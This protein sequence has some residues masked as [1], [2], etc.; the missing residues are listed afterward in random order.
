MKC[1]SFAVFAAWALLSFSASAQFNDQWASFTEDSSMLSAGTIT[2][3]N[4]EADLAWGDLDNDGA[5]DLV[6][7]RKQPFT[8]TGKRTNLLLMN[9]NGVL[10]DRTST[11]ASDAD[12][13]GDQGFQTATNDR[14][15]VLTDVD[16]DGFLDVVTATTL[17]D[18]EPKHI[19][20]PR[21][22]RNEGGS[23]NGLRFE[24]SRFPQLL[25]YGT[26]NSQNPRFCSVAAGDITGNGYP[27]LYFGD[28]DSSGAGGAQQG[29]NEDLNDRLLIND[30]SGFFT[31]GSQSRM[32]STMLTSAF[33][34]AVAIEDM[35]LDGT[36]DVVKD[37]ALNSPQNVSVSYNNSL[38]L[39]PNGDGY[40]NIH[41]VFHTNAPYH[42]SVGDLNNDG[43]PDV[44]VTDDG[45]DRFRY[46]VGVDGLG[47]VSWT[48]AK[49]FDFL[50]GSDDGFGSNNLI[51]DIDGDGWNDVLICDVDVDIGGYSRR[52]HIYHNRGGSPGSTNLT[53]REERQSSSGSAW[54]G[55]EG[56]KIGDMTGT[57]DV[58]VFDIDG[59]CD[60]DLVVSRRDGTQVW[61]NDEDPAGCSPPV[62]Q[63]D[64]GFGDGTTTLSVCGGDLGTGEDATLQIVAGPAN[65]TGLLFVGLAS[66][67][68]F[69]VDL[70]LTL[71]PFPWNLVVPVSTDGAGEFDL[72][73]PGGGPTLSLYT[74]FIAPSGPSTY[75]ASNA[76]RVDLLP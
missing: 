38:G 13:G 65:T 70:Q 9:E 39:A 69:L 4:E 1:H 76:V 20:H 72:T 45:S 30:G 35:N 64:V 15:V 31:D 11:Y 12:V 3:N 52:L 14:D 46:N 59:D 8:S 22:Y 34:V 29:S 54:V 49:T 60:N 40:F 10:T 18:G 7:V 37:T 17:S 51:A 33:G 63:T 25:H 74:Q 47:R 61:R 55:V 71:V 2:S 28:Y 5:I 48:S 43:R 58:A 50:T 24:N 53:L 62:C 56:M 44:V 27:D 19:G 23:W 41:H 75:A 42:T 73:V 21:V 66:N 26:G 57:H 68:S 6:V 32:T 16:Q 67:P 36:N